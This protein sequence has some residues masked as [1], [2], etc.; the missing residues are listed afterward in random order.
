MRSWREQLVADIR[1]GCSL[2]WRSEPGDRR[3]PPW[4]LLQPTPTPRYIADRLRRTLEGFGA[5]C[6][7]SYEL[8]F[9]WRHV[10]IALVRWAPKW[11]P[12]AAFDLMVEEPVMLH[13]WPADAGWDEIG[14]ELYP[15]LAA[16]LR[17]SRFRNGS[18][19]QRIRA[20]QDAQRDVALLAQTVS[21]GR[22]TEEEEER[23]AAAVYFLDT[24]HGLADGFMEAADQMRSTVKQLGEELGA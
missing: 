3:V 21:K 24:V 11:E 13:A 10:T 8:L 17:M 23:Y 6:P 5:Q 22:A 18:T 14:G 20:I 1:H 16:G 7:E 4:H 15:V 12:Q 2:P 19:E 9:D